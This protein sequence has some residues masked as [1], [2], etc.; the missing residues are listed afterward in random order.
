[1]KINITDTIKQA[2]KNKDSELAGLLADSWRAAGGTHPRL[3]KRIE[4]D[5]G[6]ADSSI[7]FDL[8]LAEQDTKEGSHDYRYR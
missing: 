3:M 2:L 7:Q 5:M 6:D 4:R 1:M 8:L